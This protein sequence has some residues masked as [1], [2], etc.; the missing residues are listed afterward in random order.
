MCERAF[1]AVKMNGILSDWFES[2]MGTKQGDN[3]SPNCF[4]LY[5]NPL[6]TELKS[7][8]IGV[9]F[10]NNIVTVLA[11]ADDLV[12]IAENEADLQRLIN[13]L[14]DWCFKW[15]L[16]V[17]EKTKIMHFRPK[18]KAPTNVIFEIN[19]Q[20]LEV[21]NEYKYLGVIMDQYMDFHKTADLL[22]ASAGRALGAVI[23]KV[24]ANMAIRTLALRVTPP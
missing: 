17:N 15:R 13:I 4:S 16:C 5:L 21:V 3:L 23:N 6:L 22:A 18:Y 19:R 2:T 10:E 20:P 8:G 9:S 1:C 7:S 12:L 24:K 14:Q 11:Y